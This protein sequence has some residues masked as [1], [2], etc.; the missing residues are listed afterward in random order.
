MKT[1]VSRIVNE[2][3]VIAGSKIV[4]T[5]GLRPRRV[6]LREMPLK[7][8]VHTEYLDASVEMNHGKRESATLVFTHADFDQGNYFD[9]NEVNGTTRELAHELATDCFNKRAEKV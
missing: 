5:E 2:P 8:V 9:F 4:I 7:F 1:N 6:V 3:T